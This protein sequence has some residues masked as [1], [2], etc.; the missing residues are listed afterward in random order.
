[1]AKAA[2]SMVELSAFMKIFMEELEEAENRMD[3]V[4]NRT[5]HM[6][7]A[8]KQLRSSSLAGIQRKEEPN[9]ARRIQG[10]D[11]SKYLA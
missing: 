5:V 6:P 7:Q 2:F 8:S 4:T 3:K 10:Q 1:M 11:Y 9:T